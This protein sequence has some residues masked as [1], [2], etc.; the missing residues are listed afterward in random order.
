MSAA[1]AA[2]ARKS[3]GRRP[4]PL[5]VLALDDEPDTVLT[6]LEL[7]RDEGYDACG[8]AHPLE[9]VRALR[10]FDPDVVIA[11]IAMPIMNGWDFARKVRQKMG[12]ARPMMIAISGVYQ[13]SSDKILASMSGYEF[14]VSKPCD[15]AVVLSLV[16]KASGTDEA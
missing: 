12:D 6:L 9:A 4:G 3:P 1:E 11:D 15:P 10:E 13:N 14:F 5:R 2:G 8:Y 16:K 7:L